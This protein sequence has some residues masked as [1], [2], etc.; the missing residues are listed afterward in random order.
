MMHTEFDH[1]LS[2]L[3][4][5]K[6]TTHAMALALNWPASLKGGRPGNLQAPKAGQQL[7]QIEFDPVL[8]LPKHIETTTHAMALSPSWPASL[9]G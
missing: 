7:M 5:I 6:T 8:A 2:V 4:R 9:R 3:M 1:L